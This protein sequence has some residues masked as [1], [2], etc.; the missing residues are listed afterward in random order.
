LQ[1][2]P[3][4][5]TEQILSGAVPALVIEDEAIGLARIE[6]LQKVREAVSVLQARQN[7]EG[8]FGVWAANSSASD[9]YTAYGAHFLTEAAER[10]LPVPETL[11]QRALARLRDIAARKADGFWDLQTQ[12]YAIY[13]LSRNGAVTANMITPVRERLDKT[14]PE[15]KSSLSAIYLAGSY[16]MMQDSR[17]AARLLGEVRKDVRAPQGEPNHH[18][19]LVR[20]AQ[21]LYVLSR[22][23]PEALKDAG[24][25]LVQS[26][27]DELTN[28]RYNTIASAYAIMALAAYSKA[29]GDPA[30]GRIEVA[31]VLRDKSERALELS[32]TSVAA[33]P[34]S[35]QAS[36]IR[37][38]NTEGRP[39][40][41][42][43]VE[44]GFDRE[45]PSVAA[46]ERLEVTKE[47][48]N[49]E[50]SPLTRISL[51]DEVYVHLRMRTT[52]RATLSDVAI[53]DL[54]PAGLEVDTASARARDA[55]GGWRPDS[56]DIRE[57]RVV[58]FGPVGKDLA[59]IVYRARAVNS[60]SF[61]VPPA[62]AEAMYDRKVWAVKPAGAIQIDE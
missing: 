36:A 62:Y 44:A 61:S 32:G 3:Y 16:R 43:V 56:V 39:L 38:R 37:I 13:L 8:A 28:G 21:Y 34:F 18:N 14:G 60:G 7:A 42:Q 20:D 40:F 24:P 55:G 52:D 49:R 47:L 51:G 50:G 46:G 54:L 26:M 35:D 9:F 2:Y 25:E 57:D 58:F 12:S 33:G 1:G 29:A 15:W 5:C 30:A 17:E 59:E 11:L 6:R 48:T 23:F 53:V 45:M 31:E 27:V 41:Y 10:G 19:R 4:G 22:H